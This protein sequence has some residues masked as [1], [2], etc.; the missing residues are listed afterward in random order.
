MFFVVKGETFTFMS[1][2]LLILHMYHV[3]TSCLYIRHVTGGKG[4]IVVLLGMCEAAQQ[5]SLMVGFL[6]QDTSVSLP[7][8]PDPQ[9]SRPALHDPLPRHPIATR[10]G[11]QTALIGRRPGHHAR[12]GELPH[13]TFL[14]RLSRVI[15][16]KWKCGGYK[17]TE[18]FYYLL[19]KLAATEP[20][21]V[22][23]LPERIG[24]TNH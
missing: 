20:C 10:G 6:R 5:V 2:R 14:T 19:V 12:P 9:L 3:L 18:P 11:E 17:G 22:W 4:M 13:A 8:P 7:L 23:T 1:P 21:T 16:S 24:N 15:Y